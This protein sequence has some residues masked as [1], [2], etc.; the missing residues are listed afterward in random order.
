MAM[1]R[2]VS[3]KALY[4][5]VRVKDEREEENGSGGLVTPFGV[6]ADS[7]PYH[8]VQYL[9]IRMK[10]KREGDDVKLAPSAFPALQY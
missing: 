4:V 1:Y 10:R 8:T 2:Q 7:V 6:T 5:C 3:R 9:Q